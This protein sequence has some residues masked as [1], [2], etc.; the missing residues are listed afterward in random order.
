MAMYTDNMA[1]VPAPDDLIPEGSYH[2]RVSSVKEEISKNSGEPKIVF[3]CK[4]QDE[5]PAFGRQV[6]IHASL[7]P[8]AL[9]TLKGVYKACGYNPG[10]EGHDPEMV[11]D[12]EFYLTVVHGIYEGN[13]TVNVPPYSMKS[14]TDGPHKRRK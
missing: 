8:S 9:F 13:K 1:E 5:G 14:L 3:T 2:V 7:K 4:I 12:S 10:P 6:Q 11:L